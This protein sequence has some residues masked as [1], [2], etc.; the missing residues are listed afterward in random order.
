MET[1]LPIV[2]D[3]L[4]LGSGQTRTLRP[5]ASKL[6]DVHNGLLHMQDI[7]LF[8]NQGQFYRASAAY[9]GIQNRCVL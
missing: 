9:A 3:I 2:S 1:T 6:C 4:S 5:F 7:W 8:Q